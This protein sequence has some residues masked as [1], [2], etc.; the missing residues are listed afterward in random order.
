MLQLGRPA[1]ALGGRTG[2]SALRGL[3]GCARMVR[4]QQR[5]ARA[6][7]TV[8]AG[9]G[10]GSASRAAARE[11]VQRAQQVQRAGMMQGIPRA[12]GAGL[13][14]LLLATTPLPADGKVLAMPRGQL[15]R[16]AEIALRRAIPAFN[17]EVK[18]V[19]DC[20]EVGA[21]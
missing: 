2:C 5:C 18:A 8:A 4:R 13:A 9:Q 3:G 15:P 21:A 19:Q 14:A 12:I 6:S 10:S 1:P 7:H 11:Q 20:L 17:P 16:T